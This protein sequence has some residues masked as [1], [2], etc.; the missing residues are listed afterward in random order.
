MTDLDALLEAERERLKQKPKTGEQRARERAARQWLR[1]LEH[2]W[3]YAH[4]L[5]DSELQWLAG[6]TDAT[7]DKPKRVSQVFG[8]WRTTQRP[9]SADDAIELDKLGSSLWERG[10]KEEQRLRRERWQQVADRLARLGL[11]PERYENLD[12]LAALDA[13]RHTIHTACR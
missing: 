5:T 2:A 1:N 13:M 4:L 3:S 6:V 10:H 11:Q 9:P 12:P 8:R 7:P